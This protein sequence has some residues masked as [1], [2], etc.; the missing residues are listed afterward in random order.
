MVS[1]IILCASPNSVREIMLTA[2][3]LKFDNGEYVF[4]NIDLFS[5]LVTVVSTILGL[6]VKN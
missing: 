1:V 2:R 3:E 5:R 4:F 6:L